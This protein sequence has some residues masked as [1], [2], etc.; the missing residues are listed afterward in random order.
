MGNNFPPSKFSNRAFEFFFANRDDMPPK[1]ASPEEKRPLLG[2]PGN[3][4]KA[5]IVGLPNVGKS[6]L[7]NILCDMQVGSRSRQFF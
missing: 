5:G 4:V 1:K 7:F 6:S 2:R 3:N